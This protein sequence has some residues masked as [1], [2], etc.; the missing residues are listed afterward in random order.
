[1]KTK[2]GY[3]LICLIEETVGGI[4]RAAWKL[5]SS[6]LYLC[7]IR[8]GIGS[9]ASGGARVY[10]DSCLRIVVCG[11]MLNDPLVFPASI[12]NPFEEAV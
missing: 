1:M 2:K 5:V 7:H 6:L 12:P 9:A 10:W 8:T 3:E 4:E 11:K